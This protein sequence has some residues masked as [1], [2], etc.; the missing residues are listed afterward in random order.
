[1]MQVSIY[2]RP[3][4]EGTTY[5]TVVVDGLLRS[6]RTTSIL[7]RVL[8]PVAATNSSA[9]MEQTSIYV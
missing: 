1:M 2:A 8:T 9:F 7:V 6:A 4:L 3:S 5:T